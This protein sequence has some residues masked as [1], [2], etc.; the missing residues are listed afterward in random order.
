MLYCLIKRPK[1]SDSRWNY[2]TLLTILFECSFMTKTLKM[3][4]LRNILQ[5]EGIDSLLP[6][7]FENSVLKLSEGHYF[8]SIRSHIT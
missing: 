2:P 3:T 7:F 1:F 5:R 6:F 8:S 4:N